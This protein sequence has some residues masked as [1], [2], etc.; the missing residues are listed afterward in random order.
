MRR[1]GLSGPAAQDRRVVE[2][3]DGAVLAQPVA[4]ALHGHP[5]VGE[6]VADRGFRV[7]GRVA[8]DVGG[9]DAVD[10]ATD[11][12][13]SELTDVMSGGDVA[14]ADAVGAVAEGPAG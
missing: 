13:G 1:S 11:V 12:G 2:L 7:V 3:E 10:A 5:A 14:G 9:D 8:T 4:G 6:V